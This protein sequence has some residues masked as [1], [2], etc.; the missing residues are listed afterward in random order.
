MADSHYR[1]TTDRV[2]VYIICVYKSMDFSISNIYKKLG[3]YFG[4]Y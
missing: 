4:G 1:K 3:V 2:L